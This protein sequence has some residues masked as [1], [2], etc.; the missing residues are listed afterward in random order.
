MS[1]ATIIQKATLSLGFGL[2]LSS[3]GAVSSGCA[4]AV[5]SSAQNV[6]SAQDGGGER[7]QPNERHDGGIRYDGNVRHDGNT[8][9]DDDVGKYADA[10]WQIIPD[11][12]IDGSYDS[13]FA[14]QDGMLSPDGS[15]DTVPDGSLD[16]AAPDAEPDASPDATPTADAPTAD[17][18][19][20]PDAALPCL[21]NLYSLDN[22]GDGYGNSAEDGLFC[23]GQQPNNYVSLAG[24]CNDANALIHPG[25]VEFCNGVDD[26]CDENTMDGSGEQA[27]YSIQQGGVCLGSRQSCLDGLWQ[28]DY[29]TIPNYE[30]NPEV[31]CDGQDND[32]NLFIDDIIDRP[33]QECFA[34]VGECWRSGLEYKLCQGSN[35]WSQDY[36]NCDAVAGAPAI[37]IGWDG[38]D[39]DCDGEDF[40]C[41]Y[42][43]NGSYDGENGEIGSPTHPW[44]TI[45]EAINNA[46]PDYCETIQVLLGTYHENL[47]I[48]KPL[49]LQGSGVLFTIIEGE[50]FAPTISLESLQTGPPIGINGFTITGGY[51][52]YSGIN[53]NCAV[54]INH[55][56]IRTNRYGIS[57]E[58]WGGGDDWRI[59]NNIIVG[60]EGGD[61]AGGISFRLS[62]TLI[63]ENNVIVGNSANIFGGGIFLDNVV[64]AL[65][66]NNI[67]AFN[68]PHG[69]HAFYSYTNLTNQYN[70]LFSYSS[71]NSGNNYAGSAVPGLGEIV[72]NPL[73]VNFTDDG[74]WSNDDYHLQEGSPCRNAGNPAANYNDADGSVNDIGVY[75]GPS[76]KWPNEG[77]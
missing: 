34:G 10:P 2:A 64:N 5:P 6:S 73:F 1:L 66:Q 17:A 61:F 48:N 43:V 63:L 31:S 24:D 3:G 40:G 11:A 74:D 59:Y 35:G 56:I 7:E 13:G 60:N 37:E 75:G 57:M 52:I 42:I 44:N 14:N 67:I 12:G 8:M 15:V 36:F 70:C 26:D 50:N 38:L 22:D 21:Q 51:G 25:A 4:D 20:S 68:Y 54:N 58:T 45:Q 77:N 53:N 28:D 71:I 47:T 16:D 72:A 41:P 69:L 62:G 29:S 76:G 27:P 46:D 33:S 9:Y 30:A 18:P 32:C 23:E 65:V 19:I 39:Q 55:N 49:F